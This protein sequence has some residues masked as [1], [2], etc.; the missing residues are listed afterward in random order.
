MSVRIMINKP[1]LYTFPGNKY[2]QI[3]EK[4]IKERNLDIE[5]ISI[6]NIYCSNLEKDE[7][8]EIFKKIGTETL[9]ILKFNNKYYSEFNEI[10][11]ILSK[12]DN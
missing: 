11:R 6:Y 1:I 9:P 8:K 10:E 4:Y 5:I 12:I 2:C 3:L 7:V